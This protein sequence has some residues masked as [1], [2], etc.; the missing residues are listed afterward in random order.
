[1][2]ISKY[3]SFYICCT[4]KQA[5]LEHWCLFTDWLTDGLPWLKLTSRGEVRKRTQNYPIFP[6]SQVQWVFYKKYDVKKYKCICQEVSRRKRHC[7]KELLN[8]PNNCR[9]LCEWLHVVRHKYEV[10]RKGLDYHTIEINDVTCRTIT[11]RM[12]VEKMVSYYF[13][14][15]VPDMPDYPTNIQFWSSGS[16]KYLHYTRMTWILPRMYKTPS[17]CHHLL[18]HLH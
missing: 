5:G 2:N 6:F 15:R 13:I 7:L 14:W 9:Q 10:Q 3:I 8:C 18:L 11:R 1:M 4:A 17:F 12:S 16:N